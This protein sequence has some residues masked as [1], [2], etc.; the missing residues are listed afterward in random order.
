MKYICE[1]GTVYKSKKD[2]WMT[3]YPMKENEILTNY[4]RRVKRNLDSEY[5]EKINKNSREYM[6]NKYHN[7]EKYKEYQK[8]FC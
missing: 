7:D 1:D 4:I 5:L 6:K 8:L 3:L 2:Y